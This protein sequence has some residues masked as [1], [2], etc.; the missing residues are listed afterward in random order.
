MP[1]R[2]AGEVSRNKTRIVSV[3]LVRKTLCRMV[4]VHTLR[5]LWI[6]R[7]EMARPVTLFTGQWADLPLEILAQK[8]K[9]WG[10]DGLELACWGDHFEVDKALKDDN[11][12]KAKRAM[13]DKHGLKVF[14]IS[15][16]LVGQCICDNIDDRHKSDHSAGDLGRR[17]AGGRPA[18]G[19]AEHDRCRQG[20]QEAR[21]QGRQR[22]HRQLDLA[23]AVLVPAGLEGHDRRRLRGLRQAFHA[24]PR[25]VQGGG[26]QVRPGSAPDRDRVRHRLRP[27]GHR[28]RQEATSASASTTTRA[29]SATRASIT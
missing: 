22:L 18:A 5:V 12:C 28:R 21:R 8:A 29:T 2:P 6:R 20:R 16:H 4:C 3:L 24:D 9:S 19:R 26:H 13:L 10:Y 23:P 15:N 14:A 11:Y 1:G 25:C 17:Q 27:A 7:Y